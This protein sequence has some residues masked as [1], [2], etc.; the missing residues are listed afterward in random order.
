MDL[1]DVPNS[2]LYTSLYCITN[3]YVWHAL[4]MKK[5]E[6]SFSP[7]IYKQK[8]LEL[9]KNIINNDFEFN[10]DKKINDL[11]K[12]LFNKKRECEKKYQDST[13]DRNEL[14]P[15][16]KKEFFIK[17]QILKY[18]DY[19]TIKYNFEKLTNHLTKLYQEKGFPFVYSLKIN[20]SKSYNN[21][22]INKG[23]VYLIPAFSKN[24]YQ[25]IYNNLHAKKLNNIRKSLE[26]QEN[27]AHLK[28]DEKE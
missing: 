18:Q 27:N 11:K 16:I 19:K 5:Y 1:N 7:L 8:I 3:G 23:Q 28:N 2:I 15:Y 20:S 14:I 9:L 13:Y 25:L 22:F 17:N 4:G 10:I 26:N 12:E 24:N 21:L 6:N